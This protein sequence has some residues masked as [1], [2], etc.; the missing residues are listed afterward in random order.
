MYGEIPV[1]NII[2]AAASPPPSMKQQA[3]E[4]LKQATE[5][6]DRMR[7]M[8]SKMFTGSLN[9][10]TGGTI[11]GGAAGTDPSTTSSSTET[12][13]PAGKDLMSL[14]VADL[15]AVMSKRPGSESSIGNM[16]RMGIPIPGYRS[17][18]DASKDKWASECERTIRECL[19]L[20]FV[21]LFYDLDPSSPSTSSSS[22]TFSSSSNTH[23]GTAHAFEGGAGD[24]SPN[25]IRILTNQI[26]FR[27]GDTRANVDIEGY[28]QRLQQR[29]ESKEIIELLG[30]F[31]H[32][33]MFER[34]CAE[35]RTSIDLESNIS[36]AEL[37]EK[38]F[39]IAC[40]AVKNNKG[41]HNVQVVKQ[42]VS[43]LVTRL[44][45]TIQQMQSQQSLSSTELTE[46]IR[47]T[48]SEFHPLA[49]QITSNASTLTLKEEYP[50]IVKICRHA[51][52]SQL[53]PRIMRTIWFRLE[54]SK[55]Q[56]WKHGQKALQLLQALLLRGPEIV[57]SAGL[58]RI[59]L[60]RSVMQQ[61]PGQTIALPFGTEQDI[62]PD[63]AAVLFLLLDQKRLQARRKYVASVDANL[64]P[65]L[66][67]VFVRKELLIPN[68]QTAL[69]LPDFKALHKSFMKTM[70]SQSVPEASASTV[71]V[72][73][74]V[75]NSTAKV[76]I[77]TMDL[78]DVSF[79]A[80]LPSSNPT[81]IWGNILGNKIGG[82]DVF[83]GGSNII[84]IWDDPK[85][86]TDPTV[87]AIT[88]P[89]STLSTREPV[90]NNNNAF[91]SAPTGTASNAFPPPSDLLSSTNIAF[92]PFSA[93]S[94][95]E[96][97][98]EAVHTS[99]PFT[100]PPP[101]P[102][103][104][105]VSWEVGNSPVT[106]LSFESFGSSI[107]SDPFS[108]TSIDSSSFAGFADPPASFDWSTV[109]PAAAGPPV[110]SSAAVQSMAPTTG[111][112]S[113]DP[114]GSFGVVNLPSTIAAASSTPQTTF[115]TVLTP[116]V[117]SV[118]AFTADPFA[119]PAASNLPH[120]PFQPATNNNLSLPSSSFTTSFGADPFA[121]MAANFSLP[122]T[123]S[124]TEVSREFSPWSYGGADWPQQQAAAK[125][126][127]D[128]AAAKKKQ[129]YQQHQAHMYS[130][131][132]F[133]MASHANTSFSTRK[134]DDPF[135]DL[136][137]PAKK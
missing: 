112:S 54:D 89:A 43:G 19:L 128:T 38:T 14:I 11:V 111:S 110:S 92:D 136:V 106:P 17:A 90:N 50:I 107:V 55:G 117:P 67:K 80:D 77:P 30:D 64:V 25:P 45:T 68:G 20:F 98:S 58:D 26:S 22:S 32:S 13:I 29:G 65:Y 118:G 86:S 56:N 21:D 5:G 23:T 42:V 115:P 116:S 57:I 76:N 109:T 51:Y 83:G 28:L 126:A 62:R 61:V 33:Q 81:D 69:L 7:M 39:E 6:L 82:E 94:S 73:S 8:A 113:V 102:L 70:P 85:P 60:L 97:G 114:F 87:A 46:M 129:L 137:F 53:F 125:L 124:T 131:T 24:V 132:Y 47:I 59:S 41:P 37:Q 44:E 49:L 120:D 84:D 104:A 135:A 100:L 96:R 121:G 10:G 103:S 122:E 36:I 34:F 99:D 72:V 93:V 4:G 48:D 101:P 12:A 105:T 127:E 75:Q 71:S 16:F 66:N 74:G 1:R 63:A 31:I 40:T 27:D 9:I 133:P 88:V 119:T 108:A 18:A 78:F 79:P 134:P 52:A 95:K 35:K 15:R 130:S 3:T 91:N 2:G 123:A